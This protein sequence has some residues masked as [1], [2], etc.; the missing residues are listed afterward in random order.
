MEGGGERRVSDPRKSCP[1]VNVDGGVR[2]IESFRLVDDAC[3]GLSVQIW[4]VLLR[5]ITSDVMRTK[6]IGG[7]GDDSKRW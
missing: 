4:R 5:V 7:L 6:L 3:L 2:Q 1:A